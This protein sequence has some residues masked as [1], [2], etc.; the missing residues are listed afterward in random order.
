MAK[1]VC[2]G[3][4]TPL[5]RSLKGLENF[6]DTSA[7]RTV[8]RR[9]RNGASPS[10]AKKLEQSL[11]RRVESL[12]RR[13]TKVK[14]VIDPTEKWYFRWEMCK[15]WILFYI[16]VVSPFEVAFV[17]IG[18]TERRDPLND[19][20]GYATLFWLGRIIDF[21]FTIDIVLQFFIMYHEEKK[22]GYGG[23]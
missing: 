10:S 2:F 23:R 7:L 19:G 1:S 12:R 13:P 21:F 16:S 15:L 17:P 14:G 8:T 3:N 20:G 5:S 18:Q 4:N 9:I 22:S 11:R 6:C